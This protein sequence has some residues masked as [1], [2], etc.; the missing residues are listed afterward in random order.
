MSNKEKTVK[1]LGTE[2]SEDHDLIKTGRCIE[3]GVDLVKSL[4]IEDY[5]RWSNIPEEKSV[6]ECGEDGASIKENMYYE[7]ATTIGIK[8]GSKYIKIMGRSG[9]WGFVVNTKNDKKFKY[10]D[11]LKAASWKAPARNFIRGNVIEDTLDDLRS[12]PITWAGI[13]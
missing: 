5:R 11:L 7:F 2:I 9:V 1:L 12:G 4:M 10:G 13:S 8:K 3:D 6:W